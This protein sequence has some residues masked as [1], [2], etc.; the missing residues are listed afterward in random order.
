MRDW[1]SYWLTLLLRA[2]GRSSVHARSKAAEAT[3][4]PDDR[5]AEQPRTS[6][7]RGCGPCSRACTALR[8][9]S[10]ATEKTPDTDGR[11][12]SAAAGGGR[13]GARQGTHHGG[14][15]DAAGPFRQSTWGE[16]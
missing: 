11:Q 12:S 2:Q 8:P 5:S 4:G 9:F 3:Q 16:F 14:D 15:A 7:S 1:F 6:C 13:P 10:P